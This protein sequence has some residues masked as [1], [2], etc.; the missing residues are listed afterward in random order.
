MILSDESFLTELANDDGSSTT[1]NFTSRFIVLF[2]IGEIIGALLSFPLSDTFGRKTTLTYV[3]ILCILT[4]IWNAVTSSGPDMLTARF[5]VGWTVGILMSIS[6]VYLSEISL[7]VDRGKCCSFI[8]LSSV[9]GSLF[10][11]ISYYL[12]KR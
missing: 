7:T 11:G 9:I 12:L 10:A 3:S 2:Y 8:A 4:L 1:S 6:P 5:F